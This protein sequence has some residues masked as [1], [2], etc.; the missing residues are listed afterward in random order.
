M[1]SNFLHI[2]SRPIY[3]YRFCFFIC[4][5]FKA[6]SNFTENDTMY[7]QASVVYN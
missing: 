3:P 4:R 5:P 7:F 6:Y 1:L 2:S